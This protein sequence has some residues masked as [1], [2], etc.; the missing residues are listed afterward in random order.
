MGEAKMRNKSNDRGERSESEE[1]MEIERKDE[2]KA[3][4]TM[5]N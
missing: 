1:S 5:K 4:M 2:G 3:E